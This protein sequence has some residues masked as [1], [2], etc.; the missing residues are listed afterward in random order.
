MRS[1]LAASIIGMTSFVYLVGL[2]VW[3]A[4]LYVGRANVQDIARSFSVSIAQQLKSSMLAD[5]MTAETITR[6]NARIFRTGAWIH[7]DRDD[8][9]GP[10][11]EYF[12]QAMRNQLYGSKRITTVSVSPTRS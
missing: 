2:G 4:T 11:V 8:P 5:L 1:P 3:I 10:E 7:P 9:R 6:T 12:L